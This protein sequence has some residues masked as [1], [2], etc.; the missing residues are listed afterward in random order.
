MQRRF[1]VRIDPV[2]RPLLLAGGAGRASS[3]VDVT[4][5]HVEFKFGFLF[6]RKVPRSDIESAAVVRW[7]WWM[8]IG[9]R[10]NLRGV[11][12]LIGSYQGVVEVRLKTPRRAWGIFPCQRIAVSVEDP[13]G[14]V[15]AL[16]VPAREA[17]QEAPAAKPGRAAG[18]R[19]RRGGGGRSGPRKS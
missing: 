7:P 17:A 19:S 1:L 8:G 5:E 9:W 11:I 18:G 3:Y 15:E 14:L 12:G 4:P 2:W 6:G 13:Q 16:Q 10:S